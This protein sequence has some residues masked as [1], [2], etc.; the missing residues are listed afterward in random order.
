MGVGVVVG[1]HSRG[2][3]R[4]RRAR[5]RGVRGEGRGRRADRASVVDVSRADTRDVKELLAHESRARRDKGMSTPL[6]EH[7]QNCC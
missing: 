3:V 7:K 1:G 4:L 2:G 6:Q 5:A